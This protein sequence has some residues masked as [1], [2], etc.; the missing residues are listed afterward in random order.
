MTAEDAL[1]YGMVDKV[2]ERRDLVDF[3]ERKK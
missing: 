2:L 3:E 1:G